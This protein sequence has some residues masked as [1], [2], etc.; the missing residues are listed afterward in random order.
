MLPFWRLPRCSIGAVADEGIIAPNFEDVGCWKARKTTFNL[1]AFGRNNFFKKKLLKNG[2]LCGICEWDL[3]HGRTYQVSQLKI[4]RIIPRFYCRKRFFSWRKQH[5]AG[6]QKRE[7]GTLVMPTQEMVA[8]SRSSSYGRL[9][10]SAAALN[11]ACDG[12]RPSQGPQGLAPLQRR[13]GKKVE[14]AQV[15]HNGY[16]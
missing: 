13:A 1:P 3:L 16:H 14:P 10:V 6:G 15:H 12:I 4:P 5:K 2:F 7:E 8:R 9:F 11:V